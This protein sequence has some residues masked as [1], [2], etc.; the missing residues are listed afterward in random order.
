VLIAEKVDGRREPCNFLLVTLLMSFTEQE[1]TAFCLLDPFS[2][3]HFLPFVLIIAFLF[4]RFKPP[5][6][7]FV[8][9]SA[10]HMLC[11]FPVPPG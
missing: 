3:F 6:L 5:P 11:F 1:S 8:S 2:S 10:L 7:F 9:G 4:E